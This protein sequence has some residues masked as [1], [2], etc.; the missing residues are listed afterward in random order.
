MAGGRENLVSTPRDSRLSRSRVSGAV[1]KIS[2]DV[3]VTIPRSSLPAVIIYVGF[4][5]SV[6][7]LHV[8]NPVEVY[9]RI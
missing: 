7:L 2:V 4:V 5:V 9:Y 8:V 1:A 3:G 6:G